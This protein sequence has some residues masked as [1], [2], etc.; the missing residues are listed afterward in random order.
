[1]RK[2]Q[3][4]RG[5]NPLKNGGKISMRPF[6][7]TTCLDYADMPIRHELNLDIF[8][9]RLNLKLNLPKDYL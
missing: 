6:I 5:K 9:R 7:C 4:G 1:L 8:N 3:S 2:K